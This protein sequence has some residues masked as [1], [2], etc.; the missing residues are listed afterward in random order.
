M[1]SKRDFTD[2]YLKA[3]K[4]AEQGKRVIFWDAQ[5]PQ[6]GIRVTDKSQKENV[7][8]FVLVA[9]FPGSS[10]PAPRRIGDFPAMGLAQARQIAREWRE[11]ITKGI[12]PKVKEAERRREEDRRRADTFGAVFEAFADDHLSTLRTGDA[13]RRAVNSHVVAQWGKRPISEIRRA[14]VNELI[15]AL[16]KDA[17]IGA[18]RV[19]AY[20][21]KF[22]GWCVDQDILEASPAASV[23]RPGKE[24][25]RD[26]VLS[27]AEIRAIW[28]A[29]G[30]LG[31]FG[32]AFR[33]MLA[34]G[35]RRT[36]AGEIVWSEIDRANRLWTL[37]RQRAKADRA[38]EI[39]LSDLAMSIL[40]ECPKLGD[41][42]FTTLGARPISGWS[43]A[44]AALD[45]LAMDKLKDIAIERGDDAPATFAD[46]RLHDLRRTA[47]THIA[48]LG[49]DRIVISK[50]LNHAE[51]GVTG[52]YDRH[53]RDSE[54]R[55]AMDLWGQ[56]LQ[57]IIGG[58]DGGNVLLL[59]AAR[60]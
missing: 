24:N 5:V 33:F 46:W 3:L 41:F 34:T 7:G 49:V 57:V 35:Q 13:V 55:M 43:K 31:P 8:A 19:L 14:D 29:C 22:F 38:H 21:K 2:R 52:L 58:I 28:Q 44:K 39:P 60:S 50:L 1:S 32:R 15:R 59:N 27:D 47:A 18:N 10:N 36:E 42:V 48:K 11:D 17:P 25:K 30:E 45:R 54:K 56:R 53:S 9:R 37:P 26:R 4:P 51:G 20:L 6:F 12:D 16:R 23:K 40:D